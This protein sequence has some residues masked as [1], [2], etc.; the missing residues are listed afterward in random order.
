MDAGAV[1]KSLSADE[2]AALGRLCRAHF[3]S[4]C[5][6]VR[7]RV[8]RRRRDYVVV[9]ATLAGLAQPVAIKLAGPDAPLA[10]PFERTAAILRLVR[11]CTAVPVPEPLAQD[12]SYRDYPWRYAIMTALPGVPWQAARR[13]WTMAARRDAWA[14]L[15]RAVAALHTIT[16]PACG[17][18]GAAGAVL[19]GQPYAAA[20]AVRAGRR[21]TEPRQR[22][23]FLRVLADRSVI[24]RESQ[25]PCL[26]H[27]DL[28]P[29]N[30][31]VAPDARTGRWRLTGI[32]D[33]D[34]AW[35][36]D[37]ESDLA[38]LALWEGMTGEGFWAA[39]GLERSLTPA[40]AERRLVLQ[41]LW[42]LEYAQPTQRHHADTRQICAALGVPPIT[43][44]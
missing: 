10:C 4:G 3:G 20:L 36:G 7:A 6:I 9:L 14:E 19:D 12:V 38:R 13:D 31:L 35:A 17:E 44:G 26:S 2:L 32:L 37:R 1:R 40:E 27:E 34:S 18:V 43:F 11:A 22:D 24:F 5:R 42:C 41:L 16:F 23:M 28:N 8:T 25:Q 30:L 39:Y 21:L 33:F 29:T 15:G